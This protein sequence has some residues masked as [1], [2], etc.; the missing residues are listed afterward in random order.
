MSYSLASR[1]VKRSNR[2]E[3]PRKRKG[4]KVPLYLWT[5]CVRSK[6]L[7]TNVPGPGPGVFYYVDGRG[8]Q[9]LGDG[10]RAG[11]FPER[12]PQSTSMAIPRP[13]D[14]RE[15]AGGQG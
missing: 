4:N 12:S 7:G 10:G 3:R 6:Y 13:D 11:P 15:G 9:N 8:K 1:R 5:V 2:M 14:Q